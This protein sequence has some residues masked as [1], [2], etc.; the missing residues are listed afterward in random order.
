MKSL[1]TPFRAVES[2]IEE[3]M[4][5]LD[6]NGS[7]GTGRGCWKLIQSLA[8]ITIWIPAYKWRANLAQ[9]M[10]G[11]VALGCILVA[12]SLAHANLC[13]VDFVNGPY[14]CILPPIVYAMFGTCIH[15]SVGT[16][17]LV[18]LLTGEQLLKLV[19]YD[20]KFNNIEHRTHA[21]GILSM[22]VGVVL[23]VMGLLRLAFLVR[24][25]SRPALSGFVTA[26]AILIMLSQVMPMLGREGSIVKVLLTDP[27]SLQDI[28]VPT[29]MLSCISLAYLMVA[30]KMKKMGCPMNMLGEFKELVLLAVS[31]LFCSVFGHDLGI[32]MV[33]PVSQGLPQ[34]DMPIKSADDLALARQL[35]PAATLIAI[36]AYISSFAGAKKFAMMDGYQIS[37][38]NEFLALGF[39]NILGACNGA[40]PTQIGLSRM[41][42]A[43]DM[44]VRSQLGS[45][46]FVGLVVLL[47]IQ[48]FSPLLHKVPLCALNVI[49][50]N[51]ASHLTEF[52]LM[53]QTFGIEREQRRRTSTSYFLDTAVWITACIATLMF[54]ALEGMLLAAVVSLIVIIY[55]A[56]NP[57]LVVLG[58]KA[59][60]GRWV[61]TSNDNSALTSRE[62]VF[63]FRVEGP[64]FFA[65]VERL[66][67][68]LEQ[69]EVEYQLKGRPIQAMV[70]SSLAIPFVDSTALQA[71]KSMLE[72]YKS[73]GVT[74]FIA[75]AVGQPG[76]MFDFMLNEAN[77]LLPKKSVG[78][79]YSVQECLDIYDTMRTGS[80]RIT[81]SRCLLSASQMSLAPSE[82]DF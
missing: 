20:A 33:P 80:L 40:V 2:N 28:N 37:A 55:L 36:V 10:A 13:A 23:A 53:Q 27:E 57:P 11:G 51:G 29:F 25:L 47:V 79:I 17:G 52:E 64:L 8:P 72:A 62:G 34:F 49:I 58:Y 6:G 76:R 75:N 68:W 73:R 82:H 21:V 61:A 42:I 32:K 65:N 30:K 59:S 54:G 78:H 66:Q 46:I 19:Q 5:L 4:T 38:T 63:C 45:N 16:G 71:L 56:A 43:R 12:Q 22:L 18:S 35:L 15:S 74:F 39:A 60:A 44:G 70:M 1:D 26:S 48:A 24:F 50:I 14:S 3:G 67:E 41:G 7:F 31:G 81:R 9:D 77:Q 69:I